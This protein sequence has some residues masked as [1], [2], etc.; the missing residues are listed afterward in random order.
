MKG[1]SLSAFKLICFFVCECYGVCEVVC[2][3]DGQNIYNIK[4]VLFLFLDRCNWRKSMYISGPLEKLLSPK[5]NLWF[6]FYVQGG[7]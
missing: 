2:S 5:A 6:S 7:A 3:C 4:L 1:M